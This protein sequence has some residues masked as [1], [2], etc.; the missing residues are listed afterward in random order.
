METEFAAERTR[1]LRRFL[2]PV[3]VCTALLSLF[4]V[5]GVGEF[6][7]DQR[8]ESRYRDRIDVAAM[9]SPGDALNIAEEGV[10]RGSLDF[11]VYS[12]LLDSALSRA[13]GDARR[14][15]LKSVASVLAYGDAFSED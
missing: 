2:A 12:D 13:D 1:R 9:R 10:E 14:T 5:F 15:A 6:V 4:A 8:W 11:A 3:F 7:G